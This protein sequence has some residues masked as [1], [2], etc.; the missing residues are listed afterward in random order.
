MIGMVAESQTASYHSVAYALNVKVPPT[1]L[2]GPSVA[3][4]SANDWYY[5]L[6]LFWYN[7]HPVGLGL[8]QVLIVVFYG[9]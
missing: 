3:P 5:V 6:R 1:S 2:P 9:V 7:P 4:L 8:L